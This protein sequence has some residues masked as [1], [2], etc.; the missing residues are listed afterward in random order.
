MLHTWP[1]DSINNP[2]M[3]QNIQFL[4]TPGGGGYLNIKKREVNL[5][6]KV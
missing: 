4:L 1:T 3:L 5:S 6:L 2:S